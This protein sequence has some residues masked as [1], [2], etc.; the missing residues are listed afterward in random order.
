MESH[1]PRPYPHGCATPPISSAARALWALIEDTFGL[2]SHKRVG[3]SWRN[4][5]LEHTVRV[6]NLCLSLAEHE[7]A[8]APALELAAILHDITKRFDGPF[9]TRPNGDRAVDRHGLWLTEPML[10]DKGEEN[11]VTRL[12]RFGDEYGRPHSESGANI[13]HTLLL[14]EGVEPELAAEAASIVRAHLQ[15]ADASRDTLSTEQRILC[16]ADM[17]DSNLG[18]VAFYRNVQIHIHRRVQETGEADLK[19]YV[20]YVP[21]WLTSKERF[22]PK[23]HTVTARRMAE[24]RLERCLHHHRAMVAELDDFDRCRRFGLL[25]VFDFFMSTID[26]P[27]FF[28]ELECLE[29]DNLPALRS[30]L[31]SL[32]SG[33]REASERALARAEQFCRELRCEADG[34]L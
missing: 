17:L 12:Y 10:P 23:C 28:Q 33:D 21:R 18:L 9:L 13:A 19:A 16:D 11:L 29:A 34:T 30:E 2:W 31:S 32:A 5:Y 14:L 15:P 26:D 25:G 7:A 20:E 1:G 3:F 8:D 4:Y 6:R 24:R 22:L 27:D